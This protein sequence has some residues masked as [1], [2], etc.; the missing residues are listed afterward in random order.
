[1]AEFELYIDGRMCDLTDN[2]SVRLNR[3]LINPGELSAK[4]A[5]YSYSVT[6]PITSANNEIFGF[7]N[8]EETRGKFVRLY[9]A[10]LI[11][12][13]VRIFMGNF[14]YP[15]YLSEHIKET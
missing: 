10:E 2:F 12:G 6:L 7:A 9:I 1:M 5:Q 14:R 13:G 3:Q 15:K 4:D 8:I 11:A